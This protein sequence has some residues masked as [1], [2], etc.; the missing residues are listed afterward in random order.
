MS[1]ISTVPQVTPS[2]CEPPPHESSSL[3]GSSTPTRRETIEMI[4]SPGRICKAHSPHEPLRYPRV[5]ALVSPVNKNVFKIGVR[6]HPF[7]SNKV[8]TSTPSRR[9]P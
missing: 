1:L 4:P 3:I 8:F 9:Q 7:L 6:G 5:Y 2:S